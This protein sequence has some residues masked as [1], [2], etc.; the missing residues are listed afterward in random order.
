MHSTE[1]NIPANEALAEIAARP[2]TAFVTESMGFTDISIELPHNPRF[3]GEVVMG[4]DLQDG[5]FLLTLQVNPELREQGIGTRLASA[6][7]YVAKS[8]GLENLH[9]AVDSPHTIRIFKKL[10]H[11]KDVTFLD[12]DPSSRQMVELPMTFEQAIL[13]LERV[14][15]MFGTGEKHDYHFNFVVNL[16]NVALTSLEKP[17]IIHNRTTETY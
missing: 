12:I 17:T 5:V 8:E 2:I 4:E 13:S 7:A 9:S 6:M 11:E 3:I 16:G 10:F 14:Q 15:A 1:L